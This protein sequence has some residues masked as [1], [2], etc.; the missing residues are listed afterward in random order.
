MKKINEILIVTGS[1]YAGGTVVLAE[2]CRNLAA[3]GY[4]AKLFPVLRYPTNRY[5]TGRF[6]LYYIRSYFAGIF[7]KIFTRST[8]HE[9]I[10]FKGCAV[11]SSPFYRRNRTLV[12]YPD[13]V[14]GNPIHGKYVARWMLFHYRYGNMAGAHG[15]NDLFIGYRDVF[16]DNASVFGRNVFCQTFD[17]GLYKQTNFGSRSGACYIVRKG[18]S[19]ADLPASFDGPV[20][21]GMSEEEKVE[22]FNRCEYCYSYDT[23]TCY[24]QIASACGCISVVVLE[25][26]KSKSDYRSE[27]EPSYG[28]AVGNDEAQIRWAV[29]TRGKLLESLNFEKSNRDAAKVFVE[30]A[31]SFFNVKLEKR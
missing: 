8:A 26:G 24:S 23:Q 27:D 9:P 16:N 21:D 30:N 14:F 2:L 1:F 20:I 22:M 15:A 5:Q 10:H 3:L 13:V 28:V 31:E 18:G 12:L 11:A 19:R 29:E 17:S 7:R 25:P 4:N 6:Y